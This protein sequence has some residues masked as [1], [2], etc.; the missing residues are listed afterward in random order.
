MISLSDYVL[1]GVIRVL[2][3]VVSIA[4]LSNKL[5]G[6]LGSGVRKCSVSEDAA[7]DTSRSQRQMF[8]AT[9]RTAWTYSETE[10]PCLWPASF[11]LILC[12]SRKLDVFIYHKMK[13][14]ICIILFPKKGIT[15]IFRIWKRRNS[16]TIQDKN[17]THM[18]RG[19][20]F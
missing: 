1:I 9:L 6:R 10:Q 11:V 8:T 17:H 15:V 7:K 19:Q 18:N 3:V 16:L 2:V 4:E 20:A 14:K 13:E 12:H 5:V